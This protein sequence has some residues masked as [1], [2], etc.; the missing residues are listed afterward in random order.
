MRSK[1]FVAGALAAVATVV[2]AS[3]AHAHARFINTPGSIGLNSDVALTMFAEHEQGDGVWNVRLAI[4]VPSGWSAVSCE[5][6]ATWTCAKSVDGGH[7]VITF[8]KS[9][10]AA[11][12]EDESFTFTLHTGT[13]SGTSPVPTVQTYSNGFE[14]LWV[15]PAGSSDPA[16]RLSIGSV[17]PTST[18]STTSHG[19]V[20]TSTKRTPSSPTTGVQPSQPGQ[21]TTTTRPGGVSTTRPTLPGETTVPTTPETTSSAPATDP[22]GSTEVS[23]VDLRGAPDGTSA[24]RA[25]G[26]AEPDATADGVI[27]TDSGASGQSTSSS[28]GPLIA[29]GVGA[30]VL[31]ASAG[32]LLLRRE[33]TTGEEHPLADDADVGSLAEDG[34]GSPEPGPTSG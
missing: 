25:A 32:V 17:A 33:R 31:L 19:V 7:D 15:G 22:P 13:T 14:A 24:E 8:T 26:A 21:T 2:M 16:P 34:D 30:T 5:T 9:A 3:P 18:T 11:P 6:K 1:L 23:E 27:I 10:G 29:T 28:N 4:Q 12:A 20:T